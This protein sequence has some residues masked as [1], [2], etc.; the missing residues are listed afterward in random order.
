MDAGEWRVEAGRHHR[1]SERVSASSAV[2]S[3][4]LEAADAPPTDGGERIHGELCG[5]TGAENVWHARAKGADRSTPGTSERLDVESTGAG[6][7]RPGTSAARA[8]SGWRATR[9]DQVCG[10]GAREPAAGGWRLGTTG[11]DG[12]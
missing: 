6:H 3:G 9:A 4:P 7:G 5:V 1:R 12:E 11:E 8:A 10:K 2:G